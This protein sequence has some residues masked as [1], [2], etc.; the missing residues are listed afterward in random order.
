MG[1]Q[2]CV[3]VGGVAT[4][5]FEKVELRKRGWRGFWCFGRGREVV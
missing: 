2:A 1:G 4:V 3:C 5:A